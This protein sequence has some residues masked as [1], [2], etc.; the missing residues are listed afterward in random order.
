MATTVDVE[1]LHAT[2]NEK[3]LAFVMLVFLLI[4]GVWTYQEIDDR[5]RSSIELGTPSA[6]DAAAIKRRNDAQ[7]RVFAAD[8]AQAQ[9]RQDVDFRREE[10]RAALDAG[11]PAAALERRYRSAQR[12]FAEAQAERR[13]AGRA[14]AAA[15][16]AAEAA[17]RRI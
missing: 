14:L 3:L 9:T 6:A 7:K 5:V 2:K 11:R 16:P 12:A 13:A 4:G 17:D 8:R 15:R 1:D 10:Y